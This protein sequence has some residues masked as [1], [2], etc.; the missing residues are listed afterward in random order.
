M[1]RFTTVMDP[2]HYLAS[3]ND[4]ASVDRADAEVRYDASV[5]RDSE[6]SAC[7]GSGNNRVNPMPFGC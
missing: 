5:Q 3:K 2:C 1:M 4:A 6:Q 7:T